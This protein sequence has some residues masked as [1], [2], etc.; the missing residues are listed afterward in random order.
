MGLG[1]AARYTVPIFESKLR[2]GY[3][4]VSEDFGSGEITARMDDDI[5][6]LG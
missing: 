5:R 2:W 4:I 6:R 3:L 1:S